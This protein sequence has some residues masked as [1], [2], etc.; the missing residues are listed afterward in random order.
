M[1]ATARRRR[2]VYDGQRSALVRGSRA[3]DGLGSSSETVRADVPAFPEASDAARFRAW[4]EATP[5]RNGPRAAGGRRRKVDPGLRTR[6]GT[7]EED[8]GAL[9][10]DRA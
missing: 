8:H 3:A 1:R 6:R 10:F 2:F 4:L 9:G 7:D 5:L